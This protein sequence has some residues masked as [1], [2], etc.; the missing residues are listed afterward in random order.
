MSKVHHRKD[1]DVTSAIKFVAHTYMK[2]AARDVDHLVNEVYFGGID[3][4]DCSAIGDWYSDKVYECHVTGNIGDADK[5]D[6]A[7]FELE[8]RPQLDVKIVMNDLCNKGLIPAGSYL[9]CT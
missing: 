9:I 1:K 8:E 3:R 4:Y 7:L 2:V 6:L 5:P